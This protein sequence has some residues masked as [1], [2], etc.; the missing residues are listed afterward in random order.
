[1][2]LARLINNCPGILSEYREISSVLDMDITHITLDSR[3]CRPGSLFIAAKGLEADGHD[4]IENA[5]K[6]GANCVIAQELT[7][8][9]K[10]V[11]Q[12]D[13]SRLA[14]AIVAA[15]FYHHP[16]RDMTLIGITGTNGKTTITWILESILQSAGFNA[17]VIGTVNIRYNGN[18]FDNPLT[19]PDAVILQKTLAEMKAAGITHVI[20]EA[21]SHG[22]D[23]YRVD[24]CRFN[25]GV[26][27]NLTQD[28]LDY[29][30]DLN[31]YFDCKKRLFSQFLS[32]DAPAYNQA[33]NG[34]AVINI[35]DAHGQEIFNSLDY[36]RLAVS[37]KQKADIL[38]SDITDDING[39]SASIQ[40]SNIQFSCCSS[41]TGLFNLENML[42]ATG[43]AVAL[44][45]EANHIK[46]G[47]QNC[48][49]IPGRL[50]KI[51]NDIDRHIFIDYAHTPD[52]LN[53][54][55]ETLKQRAPQR[56]ITIFGC[57]GDRDAKKRPVMGSIAAKMSDVAIVTSDN[58]RTENP[59]G[60]IQ[61]ILAGMTGSNPLTEDE[62]KINPFAKG[63]ITEPDRKKALYKAINIS[64]PGDIIV[65]AGKGHE[66]YQITNTGTIHFDDCEVLENAVQE[67]KNKFKPIDWSV[68]DLTSALENEPI[69]N[70]IDNDIK[71]SSICTDSR[72]ISADQ[73][74]LALKGENFDGHDFVDQ[75]IKK[76]IKGFVV[77]QGF[78][79]GPEKDLVERA[80]ENALLIFEVAQ[81]L[82]ALGQLARY[83]RLRAKVKLV[84]IT[85]S[86][87]KTTT[88]KLVQSIFNLRYHT[89]ATQKNYNNEIGVPQTLLNLSYAHEWAIIE[90]GMNHAGEISRLSRIALPDITLI[91]NTAGVHL[92]GLGTVE[93]VARAK[94]EI[95][96]GIRENGVAILFAKDR[97]RNIIEPIARSNSNV[98]EYLFFADEGSA[99][100]TAEEIQM[101]KETV[102]F[103]A[104]HNQDRLAVKIN[105]PARFMVNNGLAAI[106]AARCAGIDSACIQKGLSL[107]K[108]V[109]GRMN[110]YLL[111]DSVT[112]IDDAYNANPL[113]VSQALKTLAE[114]SKGSLC[115]AVLG[116]MLEL[117][118]Q[119]NNLHFDIGRLAA[120]LSI[121]WLYL[122]GPFSEQIKNG[123]VENGMNSERILWADKPE[124]IQDLSGKINQP[125]W[126]LVKG[127]RGM[128][129]ETVIQ[130]LKNSRK[131]NN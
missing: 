67:F 66:T 99:D 36:A 20:M 24:G 118:E 125:A 123:A 80:T 5:F 74:F 26:F 75:L 4:Y 19:T 95:F 34:V 30:D 10:P 78:I 113:S 120:Q 87:G 13:N 1:M 128:A 43:A 71:F 65:A 90:M 102:Q 81:P 117:G 56:L 17:G 89:L 9:D 122:Y 97:Q 96:D 32:P 12:V 92:E 111:T 31:D 41:L 101:N 33:E 124:I 73:I 129:M 14:A 18:E 15:E 35:D 55:L 62:I 88:R 76:G 37:T 79:R 115:I 28:H 103:K 57:G 126:I 116:D 40:M 83:Q 11:L 93:N 45:I 69:I 131:H 47:L 8:P 61:D 114:L 49:T 23:L 68:T 59:D 110:I 108:P 86:S 21:S 77:E 44:G 106:A 3:Q 16:S 82:I 70:T 22:L 121:D 38:A 63:H 85:G 119:S 104:R 130:G 105:S 29:H 112:I 72:T 42:C 109:D 64:K 48:H 52:A 51:T 25:V 27:T 60:I 7:T 2:K 91:T 127:S 98:S 58:P 84:A 6:N 100:L 94:A 39:L 50:Q 107:F 46:T 53:S 54:L